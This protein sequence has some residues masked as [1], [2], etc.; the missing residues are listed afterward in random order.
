MTENME[1]NGEIYKKS[2]IELAIENWKTTQTFY[3]LL[4]KVDVQ[5]QL[6]YKNK[7][8]WF[9]K[10]TE[11]YLTAAGLRI[12]NVE[13]KKY[14]TGMAVAAINLDEY[15]NESN[16]IVEKMLEPIIM[17]PDGLERTGTVTLKEGK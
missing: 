4:T 14:D 2:L 11:D 5:D 9:M 15:E 17:G 13:G 10:K 1:K 8:N 6:R 3:K 7:L 12:V 16:L